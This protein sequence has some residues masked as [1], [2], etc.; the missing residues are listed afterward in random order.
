MARYEIHGGYYDTDKWDNCGWYPYGSY[1]SVFETDDAEQAR[2]IYES[3]YQHSVNRNDSITG[4][5]L[6][7]KV[8]WHHGTYHPEISDHAIDLDWFLDDNELNVGEFFPVS[9]YEQ[10]G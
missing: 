3:I 7:E 10:E 9:I 2:R 6:H 5:Y 1:I 8:M 4:M